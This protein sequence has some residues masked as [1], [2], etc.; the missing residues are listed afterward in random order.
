MSNIKKNYF[1][2]TFLAFNTPILKGLYRVK[3]VGKENL[4]RGGGFIMASNHLLALDPFYIALGSKK[5]L[6]FMAKS[7]LFERSAFS[8]FLRLLNAFPIKRGT[9]DRSALK[10]A[11]KIIKDG[12]VLGIFPEG[13]RSMKDYLPH[14][15][16]PGIAYI[17]HKCKCDVV[18]VSIYNDKKSKVFT[19]LT[20]RYGEPIKYKDLMLGDF[21]DTE[22][23]CR[24]ADMIMKKIKELW[25]MGHA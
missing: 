6:Y 17:A 21:P 3:Y 24:A 15:A 9:F 1:A 11:I 5:E 13:A 22:D 10:F 20:V 7:E 23:Y 12:A 14:E 25:A 4:P 18:P 19:R 8:A 2:R 16:K